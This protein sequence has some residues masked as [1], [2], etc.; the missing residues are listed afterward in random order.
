M[1]RERGAAFLIALGALA[2]ISA[3]AAAALSLAS[4]PATRA[5]AAVEQAAATRA[6]EAALHRLFAAAA[7]AEF[8]AAAPLDGAVISTTFFGA[9][10]DFSA[11]D[12]GGLV[13]LNAAPAAVLHRLLTLT[14]ARGADAD[15]IARAWVGARSARAG[16]AGFPTPE[17]AVAALPPRLR[18]AAEAAIGHATTWS[19]RAAVDP[20]VATAPALAASADLTLAEAQAFVARRALEGRATPPPPG[21]D[22]DGLAASDGRVAR[23]TVRAETEGGGRAALSAVV[24]VT[25]SPR[26]PVAILAWR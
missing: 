24:R 21:A 19:G 22:L 5:A 17:A 13:D 14:G 16:R 10:I 4:G 18:P 7:S 1:R 26:A 23:L 8:R 20:W 9:R 6:A 15:A 12:A 3:L 2:L 25:E 11:Q